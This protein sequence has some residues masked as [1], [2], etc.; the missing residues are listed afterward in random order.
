MIRSSL[1]TLQ[2][3]HGMSPKKKMGVQKQLCKSL[4]TFPPAS[5]KVVLITFRAF[6]QLALV[7]AIAWLSNACSRYLRPVDL[8]RVVR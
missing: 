6:H 8:S 1:E 7:T 5:P 4:S 3:C 2:Y